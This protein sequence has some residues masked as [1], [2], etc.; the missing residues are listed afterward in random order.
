MKKNPEILKM[1]GQNPEA[2]ERELKKDEEYSRL[3][4]SQDEELDD[5]IKH[6]IGITLINIIYSLLMIA[7]LLPFLFNFSLNLISFE[8]FFLYLYKSVYEVSQV[9]VFLDIWFS[10]FLINDLL[11][12]G[13]LSFKFHTALIILSLSNVSI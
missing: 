7:F 4:E 5:Q 1:I 6:W 2:I 9:F 13:E 12:D 11:L 10:L 3:M 8:W